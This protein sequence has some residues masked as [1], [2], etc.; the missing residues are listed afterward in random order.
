MKDRHVR[1]RLSE[2]IDGMLSEKEA[3]AVKEHLN[4]CTDCMEEYEEM[5]KI[6]EHMSQMEG[7]EIPD[8]FVHKVHERM[9]KQSSLRRILKGL[10]M[11]IRIKVPLE[12]AGVAAAALLVI[13]IVGIRGKQ[14]VY[15]LAY[16]QRS[17]PPVAL[18]EQT[19]ETE[20]VVEK[21]I[22]VIDKAAPQKKKE[23]S[24]LRFEEE[25]G[26]MR[27]KR[28]DLNNAVP[29]DKKDAAAFEPTET[30]IKKQI[31]AEAV[32]P[33]SKMV[34]E[35]VEREFEPNE[36]RLERKSQNIADAPPGV[37][38]ISGVAEDQMKEELS[39]EIA[40]NEKAEIELDAFAEPAYREK[41]LEDIIVAL[42]GKIIEFKYNEDSKLLESLLIEIPA[43]EYQKL[44]QILEQS[45]DIRIP[46]PT[47]KEKEKDIIRIRLKLQH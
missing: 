28:S 6:I 7:L 34:K 30:G 43:A 20:T 37:A 9:E 14:H 2:Y 46:Y 33:S 11:P 10:F 38:K 8:S 12:L 19:P 13:Y 21:A 4:H 31:P 17:Q 26:E 27:D 1:D 40:D 32:V 36:E 29:Q 24:E 3:S 23:E 35:G 39:P 15:E 25:K 45:G 22:P 44:I 5:V 47:V 18:Q 16:A 41:N 42:G